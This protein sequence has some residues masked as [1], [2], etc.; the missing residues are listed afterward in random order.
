MKSILHFSTLS[1]LS[2]FFLVSC[3]KVAVVIPQSPITGSWR[4]TASAEGDSYGW[5]SFSTGLETGVF[6]MYENGS[7]TYDEANI[8]MQ[9]SWSITTVSGGYFDEYG[10]YYNGAHNQLRLHLSDA[11][12]HSSIDLNFDNV[13]F[14]NGH[15]TATYFNGSLIERYTFSRY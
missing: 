14:Y 11:Y 12:T 9:G 8:T 15:F 13:T 7:A 10:S 5:T 6:T 3:T 2:I 4:I 1:I